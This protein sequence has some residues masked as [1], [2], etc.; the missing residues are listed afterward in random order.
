MNLIYFYSLNLDV[1][2][3][4]K[5]IAIRNKIF[6]ESLLYKNLNKNKVIHAIKHA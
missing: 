6:F 1:H 5:R 3:Y 4:F 2:S